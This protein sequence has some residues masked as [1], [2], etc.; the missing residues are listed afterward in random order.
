[1][2][3][4]SLSIWHLSWHLMSAIRSALRLLALTSLCLSAGWGSDKPSRVAG[5]VD[6]FKMTQLISRDGK[7]V[8]FRIQNHGKEVQVNVRL[9][10]EDDHGRWLTQS[11]DIFERIDDGKEKQRAGSHPIKENGTLE[12]SYRLDLATKA[13]PGKKPRFRLR[14]YVMPEFDV[15]V[16]SS[17][18]ASLP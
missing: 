1:M 2:A 16:A 8:D 6:Q 3:S 17:E 4:D 14:L 11:V 7:R 10:R 9:E 13:A 15:P 18:A 12:S 5:G